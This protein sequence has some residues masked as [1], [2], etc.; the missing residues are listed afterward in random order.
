M[1]QE[2][3]QKARDERMQSLAAPIEDDEAEKSRRERDQIREGQR[4]ERERELRLNKKSSAL[5]NEDRDV[6]ESIALGQT[7]PQ[8]SAETMFDQRLFNQTSGLTQGYEDDE[9]YNIYSKQLFV[10]GS[11][12]NF[13]YRP[14]K[15]DQENYGGEEDMKKLQDTSKFKP[16]KDFSGVDRTKK[17]EPHEKPVEFERAEDPFGLDEF[18]HEAKRSKPLDKI[19]SSGHMKV[20][21]SG[22]AENYQSSKRT[23]ISF[24][25]EKDSKRKK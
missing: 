7:V 17:T 25:G 19:G 21:G 10:G 11:D 2:L 8:A 18:L 6:S 24:D 23:R 22:K 5:R 20:A 12:Q 13:L 15:G 14:K 3:A 9:G 16:D 4:R 1:L